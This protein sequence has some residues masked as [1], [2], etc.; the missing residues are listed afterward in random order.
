MHPSIE[1]TITATDNGTVKR[2]NTA[3][4]TINV[5]DIN[6]FPPVFSSP[7]YTK[8][9]ISATKSGINYK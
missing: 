3:N 8:N 1:L 6:E 4:I 7:S 5:R 9:I 2:S